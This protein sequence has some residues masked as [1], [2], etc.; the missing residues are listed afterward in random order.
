MKFILDANISWRLIRVLEAELGEVIHS[1]NIPIHQPADDFAI[2]TYAKSNQY[3]IITLDSDF[4]EMALLN[5]CEP[6]IIHLRFKNES[7]HFIS[8]KLINSKEE[9][10]HFLNHSNQFVFEIF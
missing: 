8:E 5:K 4:H 10:F 6:K 3:S 1:E 7:N 9:I 2:W